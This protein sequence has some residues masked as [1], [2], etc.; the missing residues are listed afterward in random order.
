M[1]IEENRKKEMGFPKNPD[2]IT[3]DELHEHFDLNNDGKVS[4]EEYAE[5][6]NYHCDN[7]ETLDDEL[8]QADFERGFKYAKGGK[9][10]YYDDGEPKLDMMEKANMLK[11][12]DDYGYY[13]KIG[14]I[15]HYYDNNKNWET[16][17]IG[18]AKG[19]KTKEGK[20]WKEKYN[21]KYG[22]D[23][24]ASNSLS[25]IAEDTG[26][27]KKGIQKIYNKGIGAYKTN[28]SS[29]RPNVKSKEQWAQARVYSAVMGGKAAK[30]DEKELKMERG[31]ALKKEFKFDK[32]F[33]IYVPSTTD[34]GEK[35]SKKELEERVQEV[36]KYVANEFGGYTETETDGGYKST[37]G[38]IIEEDI[39]K[40]S[41]FANNKD[42]KKNE[43]K[44]VKKVKDW[45]KKWGQE[46]I[47]FEF[48]GDLYYIDADGKFG[49][50]GTILG[51]LVGGYA[52]Y[53]I[54]RA[55]PQKKGFDTEKELIS[56][57]KNTRWEKDG[58]ISYAKGGSVDG[59]RFDGKP[60]NEKEHKEKVR[61]FLM[62]QTRGDID[63]IMDW[64]E[65]TPNNLGDDEFF[66][67][68]EEYERASKKELVDILIDKHGIVRDKQ[69]RTMR[70]QGK[71]IY[72]EYIKDYIDKPNYRFIYAKGGK[73]EYR[74]SKK[75]LQRIVDKVDIDG[76]RPSTAYYYAKSELNS[77][78]YAKGG[79]LGKN[80]PYNV[81]VYFEDKQGNEYSEDRIDV[82]AKSKAE[83]KENIN[84][85]VSKRRGVDLT[86]KKHKKVRVV[87][88]ELSLD[89]VGWEQADA[90]AHKSIEDYA[91]GGKTE[92]E[93]LVILE[94]EDGFEIDEI[95]FAKS[96][97]EAYNK[98]EKLN[99]NSYSRGINMLTDY[100][101]SKVE[102]AKGGKTEYKEGG[103]IDYF[104]EYETLEKH[105]P[106]IYNLTMEQGELESYE[107]T[108]R[109]LNKLNS[110][111][112]T[113]DYGLDNSP[114]NL[115]KMDKGGA[116]ELVHAYDDDGSLFG[117]G[118]I[119]KVE[120]GKT[121]VR[122]DSQKVKVFDN[123]KVKK[124]MQRGG[125]LGKFGS[126]SIGDTN[127]IVNGLKKGDTIEI[128]Y[129]D[130]TN[131][132]N[133][134]P[135]K[136]R[137]RN[138]V[139]NGKIDKITF[140]YLSQPQSVKF[141]AYERGDGKW[142]FAK[143]DMAISRVTI[144]KKYD[145]GGSVRSPYGDNKGVLTASKAKKMLDDGMAQGKPLT[146]RQKRYFGA[147]SQGKAD[148]AREKSS[149]KRGGKTKSINYK[150]KDYGL[151]YLYNQLK[152]SREL[153]DRAT[154]IDEKDI[155]SLRLKSIQKVIDNTL[156]I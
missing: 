127:S 24:D 129:G 15:I 16:S 80:K 14:N 111:G 62:K 11:P 94:G 147:I 59:I 154:T 82:V 114:F 130:V 151:D 40:V 84:K 30:V 46:A 118:H 117:T 64:F 90:D 110:M 53:K 145:K 22:N 86:D 72:E 21:K 13:L 5:H 48:E 76:E 105:Y 125:S 25:D 10:E 113:F 73:T 23:L 18:Y 88:T 93:W 138:K 78:S 33:V 152:I 37:S 156:R 35:I 3:K 19:G 51:A 74:R 69:G 134:V 89:E 32:N 28:P 143:G 36:E 104:E 49:W 60:Y 56:R 153:L 17:K 8:Q 135:L 150:K 68:D 6:I 123:D 41:V 42:W 108:E 141:Y 100:D 26:V 91:K 39:V 63:A 106:K 77:P 34:V 96:E 101:G 149:M 136:V 87:I 148:K 142:G 9:I 140:D 81:D 99:P 47:G 65:I 43:N 29:V 12:L 2:N 115:R 50:G 122:F 133:N 70:G 124:V 67:T 85:V 146:D 112:W 75:V 61:K 97:D 1:S 27:S 4:I 103:E 109:L 7:P 126:G 45:S 44:V 137:S 120:G 98:A 83:I 71:H 144:T 132:S 55:R 95:V 66:K 128:S 155:L 102:Y 31:G 57:A 107:D 116:L 121:Y 52:G 54:G 119:E 92:A 79:K 38:E 139:R 131:N 20:T 58:G